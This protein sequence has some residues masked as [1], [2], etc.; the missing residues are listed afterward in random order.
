MD[1]EGLTPDALARA[2]AETGARAAYLQ[3]FQNPT[4]RVMGLARRRE[5]VETARRCG[6]VLIE[7]DL[8]GAHIADLGLPP[9][10]ALA[11]DAVAYISGL[12][13]SLAPGVRTG[14]LLMPAPHQDAALEALRAST[15]GPPTLGAALATQWIESGIAFDI[16]A[17]VRRELA[18]RTAVAVA[19]LAGLAEPIRQSVTP[20]LWLPLGELEAERVAGHAMRSGVR[21]TPPS[22]PY[23]EGI[24][25]EGLRVCLGAAPDI[26]ALERGLSI[27]RA[28]LQP[29]HALGDHVV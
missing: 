13:K 18:R 7:D 14:F 1:S 12:S 21:V 26:E 9:L 20:H 22:A 2:A 3:P 17:A 6:I 11:P 8:Y 5:I 19:A 4:A 10:A 16:F 27:L 25:V 28:A 29:G 15:F 23:A 24:P